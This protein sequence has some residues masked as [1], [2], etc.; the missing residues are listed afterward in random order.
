LVD[1]VPLDSSATAFFT[2]PVIDSPVLVM[3]VTLPSFTWD[4]KVVYEIVT[5]GG[6][7]ADMKSWLRT[8]LAA[9]RIASMIQKRAVRRGASMFGGFCGVFGDGG[10]PLELGAGGGFCAIN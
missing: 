5:V 6:C 9:M 3:L 7:P 2:T 1:L 10:P 8:T 4:K